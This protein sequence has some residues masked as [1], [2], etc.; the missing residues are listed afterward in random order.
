MGKENYRLTAG[1]GIPML[2]GGEA[3]VEKEINFNGQGFV[4]LVKYRGNEYVLKW[5]FYD[6]L[7]HP[8]EFRNNLIQN[9]RDGAPEGSRWFLWPKD[10]SGY[11]MANG[12]KKAF[13]CLMDVPP[14]DYTAFDDLCI[15]YR[16]KKSAEKGAKAVKEECRFASLE[17]RVTA[18]INIVKAFRSLHRTGKS[19]QTLNGDRFLINAKNGDVFLKDCDLVTSDG[20]YWGLGG[21]PGYMAPEVVR[22]EAMSDVFTD[23]FSLA[24]VLFR[25]FFRAD[26]LEG[27]RDFERAA[28]EETKELRQY[29]TDPVFIYD[30]E[31]DTNRPVRGVHDNVIKLWPLYPSCLRDAFTRMFTEGMTD[32]EKRMTEEYWLKILFRL[33][34]DI[35]DCPGCGKKTFSAMFYHAKHHM[36]VCKTCGTNFYTLQINDMEI[37]LYPGLKLYRCY[38]EKAEDY[39]TI[40]GEV[41][42]NKNHKGLFGIKN[43]SEKYWQA[44]FPSGDLREIRPGAGVPIWKGLMIDFEDDIK[45]RVLW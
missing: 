19:Y 10:V 14:T 36:C 35:I 7:N 24:V 31:N 13:G 41:I 11:Y 5:Y 32:P 9:V 25:L 33:R 21:F 3:V 4:Y 1:A 27:K 15:G 30:P 20:V 12:E 34:S 28:L 40:T 37:P 23:R 6:R 16:W 39:E 17:A 38:T 2:G 29:G 22:G 18:A 44:R 8:E 45:A 43:L 26:P 42:E